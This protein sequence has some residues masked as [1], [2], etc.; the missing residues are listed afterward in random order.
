MAVTIIGDIRKH[1]QI[2]AMVAL[3]QY[4][5]DCFVFFLKK[6][7]DRFINVYSKL[8]NQLVHMYTINDLES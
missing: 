1:F 6:K 3:Y 7:Y 2:L 4:T 5:F 8:Y